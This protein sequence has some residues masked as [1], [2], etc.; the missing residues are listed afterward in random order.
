MSPLFHFPRKGAPLALSSPFN[1]KK[2]SLSNSLA[3]SL[4][5]PRSSLSLSLI[6]SLAYL[7]SS[8][9]LQLWQGM[10]SSPILSRR[11]EAALDPGRVA[12]PGGVGA[13][14]GP[15]RNGFNL[16]YSS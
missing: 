10:I 7:S 14:W 8:V 2:S 11:A 16:N 9:P 15:Q 4:S 6:S 1:K 3:L 5:R 13:G 12:A